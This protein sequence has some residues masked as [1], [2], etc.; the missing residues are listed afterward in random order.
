[1]WRLL[2]WLICLL[3]GLPAYAAELDL[4][5]PRYI[6]LLRADGHALLYSNS[7]V[8]AGQRVTTDEVSVAALRSVLSQFNLQLQAR[9]K[10]L[11]ITRGGPRDY[12]GNVAAGP[13]PEP[14]LE[15]VIV[16]GSLHRLPGAAAASSR[17]RFT[18]ADITAVPALG[19]DAVRA[20]L[21]L[22]GVSS[23]GIS[24]RP[25]IRG[26]LSDE[27][28]IL[29]DGV[30]LLEPFHLAD[31]HSPYSAIDYHT[32]ESLD[33]YS[34]GFPSRYGNRMSAV[35]DIRND[36]RED[37]YQTDLG[38][39]TF[40]Q[41]L[42]TR[43]DYGAAPGR[44]L[45]SLRRGDLSDLADYIE[46]DSG[47][48]TYADVGL[49]SWIPLSPGSDL[50]L[51]AT[52][53]EDDIVFRGEDERARSDIESSTVWA[54]L[55]TG[56]RKELDRRIT[57]S[58][59]DLRRTKELRSDEDEPKGGFLDHRQ[60][61]SLLTLRSDWA[62]R[63][64]SAL[65][66]FG[67]QL[68]YGSGSYD[69]QS[70]IDRGELADLLAQ[71]REIARDI[72]ANPDGWSGGAYM[73]AE[74]LPD[75]RLVVQP[76]L[77]WDVQ[78]YYLHGGSRD[79]W[80]PRLGLE[81]HFDAGPVARLSVGR[82]QQPEGVHELQV[83]DGRERFFRPQYAD[84]ALAGFEW[85]G[86]HL[87]LVA[88]VYHKEYKRPK[89]RSENA[90]NPFVLLP[91]METDRVDLL[92]ERARAR[93]VDLDASWAISDELRAFARY[94][95]MRAQDQLDGR[96]VD[97]RWSQDHTVNTGVTFSRGGLGVGLA[98]TWH[99]GWR[100]SQLPE[101]VA[102]DETVPLASTLNSASLRNYFALDLNVSYALELGR[103]RLRLYADISNLTDRNN[104]AGIDY[105]VTE[106][107]AGFAIEPDGEVLLGRV[108]SVGL[109]LSF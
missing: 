71:P 51:G 47:D 77:R 30:E 104:Q 37:G 23:V 38:V 105:D 98:A 44:W 42:H 100:S 50:K 15:T 33:F 21:R 85:R 49:H 55:E 92:P 31:Y 29:Q 66:E 19:S 88:E 26:G 20:T 24:A 2:P 86:E 13:A 52:Y 40:S 95:Y 39:S 14:P 60:E 43:G 3:P 54:I 58:W 10:V 35:M 76:S 103:A 45:L 78:D 1:M 17:H 108:P 109:T 79:Q 12:D 46:A 91:E 62:L 4:S 90:F 75:Q 68:S 27:L 80:S 64:D 74:F 5:L 72:T 102:A 87:A 83:L 56:V 97:R 32:I 16:T 41:Y 65:Y 6:E 22:P 93:G 89:G 99:S 73:Q 96:W 57:F 18:Q 107:D 53:S 94:S 69:H 48:P 34:G 106:T 101:F 11:V 63:R 7:L 9:G 28:L 61:V 84:Q 8:H 82:F 36:W 81:Y 70:E 25:R 67:S 59:L